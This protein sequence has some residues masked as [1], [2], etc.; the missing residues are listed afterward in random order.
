MSSEGETG[1]ML[2]TA[3]IQ[4]AI[5]RAGLVPRDIDLIVLAVIDANHAERAGRL[6]RRRWCRCESSRSPR[7]TPGHH[8]DHAPCRTSVATSQ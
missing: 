8:G 7:T 2:T 4:Q 1:A 3:A 6:T 5:E